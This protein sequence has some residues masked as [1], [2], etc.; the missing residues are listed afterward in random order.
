MTPANPTAAPPRTRSYLTPLLAVSA[1]P[2]SSKTPPDLRDRPT[3][4]A[5]GT[6]RRGC[7]AVFAPRT[8]AAHPRYPWRRVMADAEQANR[9][10]ES[11][12]VGYADR[13]RVAPPTAVAVRHRRDTAAV[14][15]GWCRT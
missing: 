3:A 9:A 11:D 13:P 14:R 1:R 4:P 5:V 10:F 7:A 2:A 12:P 15:P 6:A 8:T